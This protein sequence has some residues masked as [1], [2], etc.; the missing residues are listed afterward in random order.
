MKIGI[1]LTGMIMGA[2]PCVAAAALNVLACEPEWASLVKELGGEQ[3]QVAS[4]TTAKQDPHHIEARPS[5]LARARNADLLV[6]TGA[7]LE[8]GWLP[9]LQQQSGNGRIQVGRPGY[10]EA[11]NY[12]TML[13]VPE[14]TGRAAGH[15]HAA[16]NP[17]IHLDPRN[18]ARIAEPL[19]QRLQQ[20]DPGKAAYY[21]QRHTE[22]QDRWQQAMSNWSRQA[23]ALQ[24]Q[25]IAVQHKDLTY[26][27]S[28][29]GLRETIV[30]EPTPGIEPSLAHLSR[31]VAQA[32]E[33][34]VKAVVY[35][36][37]QSSRSSQWLGKQLDV[38]VVEFPFTVGGAPGTDDLFGLFD[39]GIRRMSA[40]VK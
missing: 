5:L 6:C 13:E 20:I 34:P 38:P 23:A 8:A 25:P 40:V 2:M 29:S 18:I 21:R 35:S 7:E 30:L 22:F 19:S 4:A 15:V 9:V 14:K 37:Y 32:R 16:G 36:A 11:A 33:Q 12:V 39:V 3:V 10:F 24:D 27:T 28:W 26:F 17:H 1:G 31:I